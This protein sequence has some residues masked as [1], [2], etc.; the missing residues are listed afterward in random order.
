MDH[1][2]FCQSLDSFTIFSNVMAFFKL[3][4]ISLVV[5]FTQP[6]FINRSQMVNKTFVGGDFIII[7]IEIVIRVKK[8][9]RNITKQGIITSAKQSFRD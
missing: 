7:E 4:M 5:M 1:Q 8:M 2:G 3:K 9:V 6:Y